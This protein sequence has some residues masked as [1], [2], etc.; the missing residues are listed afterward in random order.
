MSKNIK[1][2]V[3]KTSYISKGGSQFITL[4]QDSQERLM[5]TFP[6]LLKVIFGDDNHGYKTLSIS[7]FDHWLNKEEATSLLQKINTNTDSQRKNL[8]YCLNKKI[9]DSLDV[10]T[11]KVES[12]DTRPRPVFMAFEC[13]SAAHEYVKPKDYNIS[14]HCYFKLAIPGLHCLYFEGSDYTNHIYYQQEHELDTLL[15]LVE[16]YGL[17]VLR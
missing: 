10:V 17:F 13:K 3:E 2:T 5:T 9:I 15:E 11:F 1:A 7:V 16:Q 8:H 6:N 12:A 14:D 4:N